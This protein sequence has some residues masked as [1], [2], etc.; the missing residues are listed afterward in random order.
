MLTGLAST[1]KAA[2]TPVRHE[3]VFALDE[4]L[5]RLAEFDHR[6]SRIVEMHWLAA[7]AGLRQWNINTASNL[8]RSERRPVR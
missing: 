1:N 4:A 2:Y 7:K 3:E 8:E 5:A 6:K